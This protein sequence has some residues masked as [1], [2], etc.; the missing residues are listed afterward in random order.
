MVIHFL[1]Y[2]FF[3]YNK[4]NNHI[5]VIWSFFK[6]RSQT[7]ILTSENKR[8]TTFKNEADPRAER[9]TTKKTQNK[10]NPNLDT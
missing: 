8:M 10:N 9:K 1:T 2:Y 4:H 3:L 7:E 5:P 6:Q